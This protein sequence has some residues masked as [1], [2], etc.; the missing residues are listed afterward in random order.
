MK[1]SKIFLTAL[2][3]VGLCNIAN[4]EQMCSSDIVNTSPTSRFTISSNGAEVTDKQTGLTWQR[5][6]LGQSWDGATC[7]GKPK[8]FQT[9]LGALQAAKGLGRDYRLPNIKEYMSI[10]QRSC[11]NPAIN[12]EVFPNFDVTQERNSYQIYWT[13]TPNPSEDTSVFLMEFN[14]GTLQQVSPFHTSKTEGALVGS[15]YPYAM[16]VKSS[17]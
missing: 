5:C 6:R 9:W 17:K 8:N 14:F 4:A 16:A 1:T 15:F 13:S 12:L 2:L 10:V 11:A 7:T 3:S